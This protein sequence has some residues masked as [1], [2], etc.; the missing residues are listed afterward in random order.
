LERDVEKAVITA[1]KRAILAAINH[2]IGSG[3]GLDDAKARLEE[4][5]NNGTLFGEENQYM[6]DNTISNWTNFIRRTVNSTSFKLNISLSEIEVKPY[7]S[8]NL[9]FELNLT[10]NISDKTNYVRI[11]KFVEKDVL[12]PIEGFEDPLAPLKTNGLYSKT[13]KKSPFNTSQIGV[14]WSLEDMKEDVLEGYYHP[15]WEGASFLDRL[16][17]RLTTSSKYQNLAPGR[18]IGLEHFVNLQSLYDL[19]LEIK[20]NKTVVDHLYW[21]SNTYTS[22][23]VN[24]LDISW[25][26]IDNET[27]GTLTH[28]QIYGVENLLL[29]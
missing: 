6:K 16:E 25:F 14:S 4:L 10:I 15:S 19:D 24:G 1:G 26:R 22:Y 21:D 3:E 9:L 7:D 23:R 12:V 27:C 17:G 5:A 2:T 18:Q 20:E 8:F 28:A 11:D 29:P 13:I